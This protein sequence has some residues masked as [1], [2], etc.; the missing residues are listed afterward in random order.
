MVAHLDEWHAKLSLSFAK[1]ATGKTA[2]VERK[3]EGPLLVQKALYPEGPKVCHI[4]ILHP[5]SGIAGGDV[6][7]IDIHASTGAHALLTTPGATRWYKANGRHASQ[8]IHI[9][10]DAD[11]RLDWLPQENIVFEQAQATL[12]THLHLQTG[13]RAIGW[14]IT[15]MGSI[16]VAPHWAKGAFWLNTHMTLDE[17]PIW[18]EAGEIQADSLLR[19]A[20]NGLAGLPV[21]A[22]L[23]AFGPRLGA[24]PI[25]KLAQG[26]PWSD[27]LRAGIS[28]LPQENEQDL[29]LLRVLGQHTAEVKALLIEIWM[30]LRPL[31]LG[32]RGEYLRLWS[33]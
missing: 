18:L 5:P 28:C 25:E 27:A 6:L 15:Q 32:L 30:V 8:T 23:W 11:A 29:Y 9:A 10:L 20:D 13:S 31:V 22:T 3:H 33:T 16:A 1:Q 12:S 2:L 4:A 19:G 21:M 17:H 26:L 24:E 14:E 7:T